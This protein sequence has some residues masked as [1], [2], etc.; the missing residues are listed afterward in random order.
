MLFFCGLGSSFIAII[1]WQSMG[2][3]IG[4]GFHSHLCL[5]Y[6]FGSSQHASVEYQHAWVEFQHAWVS[7]SLHGS[8]SVLASDRVCA[9]LGRVI[10]H[11]SSHHLLIE[12]QH[13]WVE[14]QRA[15]VEFFY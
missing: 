2:R 7:V 3:V 12:F 4:V 11:E 15:W 10:M 1:I 5:G 13:A 6:L 8:S 9:C 14:C